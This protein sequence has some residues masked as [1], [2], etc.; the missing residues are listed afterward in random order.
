M[1]ITNLKTVDEVRFPS[2]F[3]A[4][5]LPLPIDGMHVCKAHDN[6][7]SLGVA[8]LLKCTVQC[9]SCLCTLTSLHQH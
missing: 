1:I 8:V 3:A 7:E 4:V 6:V 2:E 9:G 5:H